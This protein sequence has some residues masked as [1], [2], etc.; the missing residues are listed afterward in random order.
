MRKKSQKCC[1]SRVYGGRIPGT[2]S[3]EFGSLVYIVNSINSVE[4]YHG[5]FNGFSL[6]RV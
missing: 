4:F 6:A 1:F 3:M 2:F 5:S